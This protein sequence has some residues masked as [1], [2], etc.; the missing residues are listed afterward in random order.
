NQNSV[1]ISLPNLVTGSGN[2]T[3]NLYATRSVVEQKYLYFESGGTIQATAPNGT[4]S[5]DERDIDE[6]FIYDNPAI[7]ETTLFQTYLNG[8]EVDS[9]FPNVMK[10]NSMLDAGR[11]P[12]SS[13]QYATTPTVVA[14]NPVDLKFYKIF[15]HPVLNLPPTS[16]K[17]RNF[18]AQF[19]LSSNTN[20]RFF[21]SKILE[22]DAARLE[23][24]NY[25][26]AQQAVYSR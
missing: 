16:N 13:A 15:T 7:V 4:L 1:R 19:G 6:V 14:A 24:E 8:R 17:N 10:Y 12:A 21:F 5:I 18:R 3:V 25:V 26:Q 20:I 9:A 2:N 11:Y 22:T 23:T